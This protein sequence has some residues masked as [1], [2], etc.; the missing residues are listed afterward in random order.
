M[1]RRRTSGRHQRA[2]IASS[3]R[4]AS[5]RVASHRV[6]SR[7]VASRRATT[8]GCRGLNPNLRRVTRFRNCCRRHQPRR[9]VELT[10]V[11]VSSRKKERATRSARLRHRVRQ[12]PRSARLRHRVRQA[13]RGARLRHRVRQ[14]SRGARLRHRV[15]QA[16]RSARLRHRVR[17][18]LGIR[19]S[20]QPSTSPAARCEPGSSS[21][22]R[23]VRLLFGWRD[24]TRGEGQRRLSR[25][26]A[27]RT[28]AQLAKPVEVRRGRV[29]IDSR[30][31]SRCV[32]SEVV[33]HVRQ[34]VPHGAWRRQIAS[35]KTISPNPTAPRNEPIHLPRHANG[36]ALHASR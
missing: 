24:A 7:R 6:A 31:A 17:L 13:S 8:A 36:Q 10:L 4:I 9:R 2:R 18:R 26:L 28:A 19:K 5:R 25:Q 1:Q 21:D 3:H 11:T 14:A 15:R 32:L 33:Q 34:R 12:A 29:G 23:H 22:N 27:R 20:K 30:L 16:P 35:K